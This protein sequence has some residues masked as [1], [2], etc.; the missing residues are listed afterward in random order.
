MVKAIKGCLIE[1]EPSIKEVILRFGENENFVIEEIDDMHL[2]VLQDSI[3]KIKENVAKIMG[4]K[5]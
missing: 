2:F 4:S 5:E 1:T 3:K